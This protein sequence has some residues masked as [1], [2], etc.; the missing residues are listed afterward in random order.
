MSACHFCEA[1]EAHFRVFKFKRDHSEWY[2]AKLEHEITVAMVIRSWLP[3]KK[4]NCGR[5]TDYRYRGCGY[6]LNYC[7]ECGKS[8]KRSRERKKEESE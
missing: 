7:P 5:I 2:E 1:Y 3:G 8:L 4:R 6:A